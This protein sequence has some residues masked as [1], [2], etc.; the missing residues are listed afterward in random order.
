MSESQDYLTADPSHQLEAALDTQDVQALEAFVRETSAGEVARAVSRLNDEQQSSLMALLSPDAAAFLME[1]LSHTQAAGILDDLS[2]SEA[3]AI[4]DEMPSD[5][6]ADLLGQ[7]ERD[8]AAAIIDQMHPDEAVD[9]RLLTSYPPESAGGLMITEYLAFF[10]SM[11]V[12]DVLADIRTNAEQYKEYDVQY[13]YVIDSG[14]KLIGVVRLRDLVMTPGDTRIASIMIDNP[15]YVYAT[16]NLDELEDFFD[17]NYFYA[18]PVVDHLSRLIGVVRRASVEEAL[19]DRSDMALL[20][21]GGIVAGEELRTMP[22]WSRATRRLAFLTPNIFLDLISASVVAFFQPTIAKVTALAIFLPVL[23][24]MAGCSGNQAVAVSIRELALGLVRA[25]E[26]IHTVFKEVTV[27]IING[28]AL[29][30]LL[31]LIAYAMRGD[32]FVWIGLVVGGALAADTVIAVIVGGTIP[33]MLKLFKMDPAM[34][35]GPI[36]TTITDICGFFLCL[37]TATMF[38]HWK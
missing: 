19:G 34:A 26:I 11:T 14:G 32:Q 29:G 16:A 23:S 21:F 36:L 30:A 3:A 6:Q 12:G 9:A 15:K 1:E 5:E 22:I 13:V 25:D 37:S 4:L 20:R 17:A 7:L 31:G 8:E 2:A 33:L 28:I 10:E 18:V 35:S 38:I 24:D 27:G